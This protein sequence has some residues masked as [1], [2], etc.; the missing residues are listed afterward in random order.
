MKTADQFMAKAEAALGK[1]PATAALYKVRDPR[2]V[3]LL[4]AMAAM[5]ELYSQE[6]DVAAMEPFTKAR[7]V[8]VLA[9]A[10]VKGVLPYG[11]GQVSRLA[12]GNP[13][14]E[15]LAL[16][17]GRRLLDPQGRV[18][19]ITVGATVAAG[20]TG[21]ITVKQ[22]VTTRVQHTVSQS[23]P[24]Y[25]IPIEAP[26]T[27][28]LSAVALSDTQGNAYGF[29]PGF[30]NTELGE[31]AFT[32]E[33][34]ERRQLTVRLG[35]SEIAGYQPGTGEVLQLDVSQTE[36][37]ITLALGA[38]FILEHTATPVDAAAAITLVEVLATG[39]EP[40][41]I[42]TLREVTS[43]P[44]LYDQSAVYLGGFDY[45]LRT[46]LPGFRFL[47]V[48]NE[49][50]EE[51]VRGPSEDNINR[52]FVAALRDGVAQATLEA[53]IAAV[54]KRAD[55]SYRLKFVAAVETAIP[56]TVRIQVPSVYDSGS[57]QSAA[58][59]LILA[60]Y[61]RDSAFAKRGRGRVLYRKLTTLLE[62]NIEACQAE[63]ADIQ[64]TVNDAAAILPESYRYV[65]AAS[66]TI[67]VESLDE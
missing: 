45:L 56:I 40:M 19:V 51:E 24:F 2:V 11:A 5:L 33:S 32:L 6:Q 29:R 27:G 9:D 36:G 13:A 37:P 20:G 54:V 35:A 65:S 55:D 1:Y 21:S 34:D 52:L 61:G 18:H 59:G 14:T 28:Y 39:A 3:A 60:Q 57:V 53:D 41:S 48:W 4:G 16:V 58:Q 62:D 66:L 22:E 42:D 63:G 47:S 46:N 43:Y 31:F 38:P 25:A 10:A 15:A 23:A 8:T 12:V 30:A 64:V 7:D 26:A 44:S 50:I 49:R 67:V 17:V